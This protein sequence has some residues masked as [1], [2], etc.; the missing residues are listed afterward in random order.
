M[1]IRNV[2]ELVKQILTFWHLSR[3]FVIRK[4][5]ISLSN[6]I[7]HHRISPVG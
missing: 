6:E 2:N 5:E 4:T 1:L 7:R 3:A